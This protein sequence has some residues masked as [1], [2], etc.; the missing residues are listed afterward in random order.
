MG[1]EPCPKTFS[2]YDSQVVEIDSVEYLFHVED[3]EVGGEQY[4]A[5]CLVGSRSVRAHSFAP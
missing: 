1:R 5:P 4:E 3:K 2:T